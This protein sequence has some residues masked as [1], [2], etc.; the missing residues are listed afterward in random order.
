[1]PNPEKYEPTPKEIKKA[2]DIMT[3]EQIRKSRERKDAYEQ[4][5]VAG[6]SRMEDYAHQELFFQDQS[7]IDKE[8]QK[9][10]NDEYVIGEK[11]KALVKKRKEI[12]KHIERIQEKISMRP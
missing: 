4:G 5:E 12:E 3:N 7:F 1:M 9:L 11:I 10:K 6:S 2:E 8:I